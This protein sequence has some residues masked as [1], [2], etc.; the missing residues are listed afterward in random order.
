MKSEKYNITAGVD[1]VSGHIRNGHYE[2]TIDKDVW[3]KMNEKEQHEYL[4]NNGEFV[5]DD[6]S[7]NDIGTID[8]IEK[9]EI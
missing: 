3:D 9:E 5:I 2:L 6:Y 1:Y 7:I 8:Y 4:E